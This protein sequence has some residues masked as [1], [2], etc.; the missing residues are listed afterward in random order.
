MIMMRIE[1][2]RVTSPH[3]RVPVPPAVA[4]RPRL[5]FET[6]RDDHIRAIVN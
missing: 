5:H 2:A 3:V 4:D 6:I 1:I